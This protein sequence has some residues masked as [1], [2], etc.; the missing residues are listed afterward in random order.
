MK[1]V[2]PAKEPNRW[3]EAVLLDMLEEGT[4]ESKKMLADG[5]R[6]LSNWIEPG[7]IDQ[8]FGHWVERYNQ[9]LAEHEKSQSSSHQQYSSTDL[10]A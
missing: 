10:L 1:I 5:I 2:D 8:L 3:L 6:M 7:L 4:P 9:L